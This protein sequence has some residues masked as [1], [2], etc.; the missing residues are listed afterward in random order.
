MA[1]NKAMVSGTREIMEWFDRNAT[2]PYYSVWID[3]KQLLFSWNDDDLEAGRTKL[4]ND[5][6]AFEQNGVN[7]LLIIKLHPKKEKGGFITDKSPVYG[8]LNFRPSEI[9]KQVYPQQMGAVNNYNPRMESVIERILETQNAILTKLNA[10]ELEEEE[11]EKPTGI[12][13]I[14][15][16]PQIQGLLMA[17]VS[18]FLGLNEPS[19]AGLAGIDDVQP[20]EAINILNSLM[21][22][23][24]TIEHLRKLDDMNSLKLASLLAML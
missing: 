24:V 7:E 19:V 22:K 21:S 11:E 16:N 5:L 12:G 4:E 18:K 17:G 14:L 15:N 10:E 6:H 3:R 20:N 13:A 8:S 9:E 23:G 2:A 1:Y